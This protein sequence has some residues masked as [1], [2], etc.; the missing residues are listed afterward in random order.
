MDDFGFNQDFERNLQL[1]HKYNGEI[2][3]IIPELSDDKP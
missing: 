2:E 3:R 1:C